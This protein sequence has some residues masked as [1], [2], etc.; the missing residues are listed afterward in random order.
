MG[1]WLNIRKTKFMT[2]GKKKTFKIGGETIETVDKFEYL[3]SMIEVDGESS[4]EILTGERRGSIRP[5]FIQNLHTDR[6]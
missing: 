3:G 6:K 4:K 5:K 2:T 1:L